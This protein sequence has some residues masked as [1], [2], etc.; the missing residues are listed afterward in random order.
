MGDIALLVTVLAIGG[1]WWRGQE[2]RELALRK[3][4]A[5]CRDLG[6]QLL[7][8]SVARRNLWVKRDDRGHWRIWRSFHF[9]FT[10]TG[11]ERYEGRVVTLGRRVESVQ[12]PPHRFADEDQTLH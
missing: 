3:A 10:A 7:D 2:V 1:W 12:L 9:E 5:H 4:R 11:E 8:D 6:L